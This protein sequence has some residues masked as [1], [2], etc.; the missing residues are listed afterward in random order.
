MSNPVMSCRTCPHY[1][2]ESEMHCNLTMGQI[3]E[4]WQ[5][6]VE[7]ART[8]M[9]NLLTNH[10][11][12]TAVQNNRQPESDSLELQI[13]DLKGAI[14]ALVHEHPD[15]II[16]RNSLNAWEYVTYGGIGSCSFDSPYLAYRSYRQKRMEKMP[17][18]K[19]E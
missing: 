18:Y 15:V 6:K 1:S 5:E 17:G 11:E 9:Q 7:E 3:F 8:L 14:S 16:R 12:V 4:C 2:L 10:P 19:K 13:S